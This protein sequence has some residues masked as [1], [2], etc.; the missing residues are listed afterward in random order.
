M[1]AS[2]N[3]PSL[4]LA[5]AVAILVLPLGFGAAPAAEQLSAQD[6]IDALRS[7]ELRAA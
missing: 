3:R 2:R 4:G 6:I 5:L 7:P 1:T